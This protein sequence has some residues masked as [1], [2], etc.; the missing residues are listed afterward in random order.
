MSSSR[1]LMGFCRTTVF[2]ICFVACAANSGKPPRAVSTPRSL[3][4]RRLAS[5]RRLASQARPVRSFPT[6]SPALPSLCLL[7]RSGVVRG[8]SRA[9]AR[10]RWSKMLDL[11]LIIVAAVMT[12]LVLIA[13]LCTRAHAFSTSPHLPAARPNFFF[14]CSSH[15]PQTCL[16]TSSRRRIATRL[17]RQR[18]PS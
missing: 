15:Q 13:S 14:R 5:D 9:G 7:S 11:Y 16:Y 18:L 3:P 17:G 6:S 1:D 8:A 10:L 4:M 12:V 2:G